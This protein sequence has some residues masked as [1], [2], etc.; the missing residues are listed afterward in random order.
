MSLIARRRPVTVSRVVVV[1]VLIG[2]ALATIA[3]FFWLVV[4]SLKT[5]ADI[6]ASPLAL[7]KAPTLANYASLF[8]QFHFAIATL[9]SVVI[10]L[11]VVV[12][13][14]ALGGLAA[15]GF[16]RYPFPGSRLLLSGLL[17]T[18]MVTPAALVVPLYLIMNALGLL[19]TLI[20]IVLGIAVLNLPFVIWVLRPFFDALPREIEEAGLVDG[21]SPLGVFLRIAIRLAAPGLI[22]VALLSFIA[23][24]TDLL[25]PISF[26]T[27]PEATPLTAGL[28]QMQTGYKIYW[29]SLMAGGVYL[30][31]PTLILSFAL[32]KYLIRG[33]RLG[34]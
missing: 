12:I 20:S 30:T 1:A 26:T 6:F 34:Y 11:G 18:R 25:F 10:S 27:T 9:N 24:W 28:L 31:L 2:A 13:S 33:M 32:Q 21:L 22:T 7:L 3:P 29:G 14:V 23:G 16:S 17:I 15:Y 19:N 8:K 5:E 4:S